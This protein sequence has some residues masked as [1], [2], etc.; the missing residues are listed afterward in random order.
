MIKLD[1]IGMTSRA[2]ESIWEKVAN[3]LRPVS[4]VRSATE[5]TRRLINRIAV[6]VATL[7]ILGLGWVGY[8][9][10]TPPTTE[11]TTAQVSEPQQ[12]PPASVAQT[13]QPDQ[14]LVQPEAEP[15]QVQPPTVKPVNAVQPFDC[16]PR[17]YV[18]PEQTSTLR[19]IAEKYRGHRRKN[20]GE[21]AFQIAKETGLPVQ[22]LDLDT[23]LPAGMSITIP[24]C[25]IPSLDKMLLPQGPSIAQVDLQVGLDELSI[26]ANSETAS[27][28]SLPDTL[29]D[30]VEEVAVTSTPDVPATEVAATLATAQSQVSFFAVSSSFGG[31][32]ASSSNVSNQ[33]ASTASL[34]TG[35][36]FNAG[37]FALLSSQ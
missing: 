8:V 4:P 6:V 11:S 25:P 14:P 15:A 3:K 21:F 32:P 37:S 28:I 20:I 31:C 10:F 7:L 2:S 19:M 26:S 18:V 1:L 23:P 22:R 24:V 33:D 30:P 17:N 29:S 12:A 9:S 13:I 36:L 35:G 34:F 5:R 27:L 16:S